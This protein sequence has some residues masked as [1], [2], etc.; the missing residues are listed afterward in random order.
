VDT[1]EKDRGEEKTILSAMQARAGSA[2]GPGSITHPTQ[3]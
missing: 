1:L 3:E 2:P